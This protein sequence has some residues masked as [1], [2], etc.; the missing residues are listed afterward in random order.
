[1]EERPMSV[2]RIPEKIEIVCDVCG[3]LTHQSFGKGRRRQSGT[4]IFKQHALDALGDPAADGT[5]EFDLCDACLNRLRE[6]INAETEKIKAETA[7]EE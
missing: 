5:L 3:V 6:T 7:L 4:L 2:K 1:M